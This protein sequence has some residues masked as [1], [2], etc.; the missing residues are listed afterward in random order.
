MMTNVLP[1]F[2]GSQFIYNYNSVTVNFK[3]IKIIDLFG[4]I[5]KGGF[6]LIYAYIMKT[7]YRIDEWTAAVQPREYSL[8]FTVIG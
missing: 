8:K 6:D 2:Y 4:C 5:I 1:P 7:R 3:L